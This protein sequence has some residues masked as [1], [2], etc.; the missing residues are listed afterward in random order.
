MIFLN[1]I[2]EKI[3]NLSSKYKFNLHINIYSFGISDLY[4]YQQILKFASLLHKLAE[5][6][7]YIYIY[8]SSYIF[9]NL[10][11]KLNNSLGTDSNSILIFESIDNFNI[12]FNNINK[13]KKDENII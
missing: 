8:E 5:N 1:Y 6:I 3:N 4:Y 13:N 9:T 12:K 7:S 11:L 2:E 10:I